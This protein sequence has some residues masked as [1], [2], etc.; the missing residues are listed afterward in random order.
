[1]PYNLGTVE[2]HVRKAAEHFGERFGIDNIGGWRAKGSVP[3]SDHPRGLALDFMTRSKSKGD[4]LARDVI[5]NSAN[6]NV[7]YVIWWRQIWFP[8]KGWKPYSGP[9]DHTDHVH[10]SFLD[11]PG[12]GTTDPAK[13]GG[14]LAGVAAGL[15]PFGSVTNAVGSLV[16]PAKDLAV[17]AASVGKFAEMLVSLFLPTNIIRAVSAFAGTVFVLMGI[18]FLSREVRNS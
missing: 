3:G 1:M 15:N 14:A 4:Q 16:A 6:W 9:S 5:A 12:K 17:A 13:P 10:V 2:A 11:K 8:G 18:W 7:K